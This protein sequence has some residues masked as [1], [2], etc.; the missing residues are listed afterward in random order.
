MKKQ[1]HLYL[2]EFFL[3]WEMCQTEVVGKIKTHV[4]CSIPFS[5]FKIMP[6]KDNVEKRVVA[7]QDTDDSN[8]RRIPFAGYP[9][10]QTRTQ[11]I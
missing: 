7:R 3:E 9:R 8:I 4:L 5:F 10:L 2:A 6:F 1:A 11:I